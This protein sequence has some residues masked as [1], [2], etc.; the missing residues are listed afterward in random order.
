M[1]RLGAIAVALIAFLIVDSVARVYVGNQIGDSLAAALSLEGE[2]DVMIGGFP[3]LWSAVTGEL[4]N[5]SI[6]VEELSRG[7]VALQD[8]SVTLS[9]VEASPLAGA[10]GRLQR[11]AIRSGR[12][13]AEV[14]LA[15]L[16]ELLG[17]SGRLVG[18]LSLAELGMPNV[19]GS[20]LSLGPLDLRLP[21]IAEG[22]TYESAELIDGRVHLRFKLPR[23]KLRL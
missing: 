21:V 18:N 4:D 7:D 13:R 15:Q 23:T 17:R 20:T 22:M 16:E 14:R 10:L 3:F 19:D 8:V 9:G 6:S 2:P 12:G 5:V 1:R 11:V